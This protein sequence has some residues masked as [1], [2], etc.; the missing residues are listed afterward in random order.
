MKR[1]TLEESENKWLLSSIN[2][3]ESAYSL[4]SAEQDKFSDQIEAEN[5]ALIES[6]ESL[7]V[8]IDSR[9][10]LLDDNITFEIGKGKSHIWNKVVKEAQQLIK[11]TLRMSLTYDASQAYI[12]SR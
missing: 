6:I 3:R 1:P 9:L 12:A 4:Y 10:M 2:T 7:L 11:I 8:L 5:K